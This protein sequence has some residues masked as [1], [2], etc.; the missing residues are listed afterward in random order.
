MAAAKNAIDDHLAE[1]HDVRRVLGQILGD[2]S[3]PRAHG[4]DALGFKLGWLDFERRP[5]P[6]QIGVPQEGTVAGHAW[7]GNVLGVAGNLFAFHQN[8]ISPGKLCRH[9]HIPQNV[10]HRLGKF[11]EIVEVIRRVG[12]DERKIEIAQ[13]VINRPPTRKPAY[14]D[15]VMGFHIIDV[16]L[17]DGDLVAPDDDGGLVDIKHEDLIPRGHVPD[18]IFFDGQVNPGVLVGFVLNKKHSFSLRLMPKL[19]LPTY[20]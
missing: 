16:D 4:L 17:L 10:H 15:D 8:V 18:Q 14:N 11:L 9:A 3:H 5:H 2:V 20:N 19:Y 6:A 1:L 12:R 7:T 13:V